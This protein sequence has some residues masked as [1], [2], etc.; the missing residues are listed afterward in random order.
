MKILKALV[1][2]A[3]AA[4]ILF[5]TAAASAS[6]THPAFIFGDAHSITH[7]VADPDSGGNGNWALDNFWRSASVSV[8]V[9]TPLADCGAGA[10]ACYSYTATITD[11]G[12]FAT[13][14]GAFTPNQGGL[15]AGRHIDGVVRGSMSGYGDF[16]T[17]YADAK[18]STA[19]NAGVPFLIVGSPASSLFP[20]RLF[21]AGTTFEGLN[22]AVW[23]YGYTAHVTHWVPVLRWVTI[24]K[25]GHRIHVLRTVWVRCTVTQH[26]TDAYNNGGG[27]SLTAGNITG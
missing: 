25:H 5:S 20:E 10:T 6:T 17:F 14:P 19:L 27:Q 22:E 26:W 9:T 2:V 3:A 15:N 13:I 16:G 8:P 12:A 24:C 23:S 4:G 18:P 1:P 11:R 21:P 7:V